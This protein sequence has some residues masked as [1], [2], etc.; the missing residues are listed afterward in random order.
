MKLCM[1][2]PKEAPIERG[3]PGRI[4]GDRVIQ[5]AA[6]TLQ[7]FFTGG[8]GAREHAEYPLAEVDLRAPVMYPPTVRLFK[9]QSLDFEFANTAS[10]YGPEDEIPFPQGAHHIDVGLGLAAMIGAESAIGGYTLA[11][12]WLAPD[13]PGAKSRDFALSIG[14]A[15]VTELDGCVLRGSMAGRESHCE[16]TLEPE[17]NE[18]VAHAVRNTRLRP[19]D[20]LIV[21]TGPGG[22]ELRPGD[23]VELEADEIGVL[24]N[25]V[26]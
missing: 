13:L 11:N 23:V 22:F 6:Q 10:I 15:I 25:R 17:W 9:P 1:F 14:P 21:D 20:L 19:G 3:W 4:D 18:I 26:V 5:L 12:T 16:A 24:R 8:G 2:S 7:A